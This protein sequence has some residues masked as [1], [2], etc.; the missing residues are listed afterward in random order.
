MRV[1]A[2]PEIE[3]AAAPE[4]E[5]RLDGLCVMTPAGERT[6][7]EARPL[8]L[9]LISTTHRRRIRLPASPTLSLLTPVFL[10]EPEQIRSVEC[11]QRSRHLHSAPTAAPVAA[12]HRVAAQSCATDARR[13][14]QG[15]TLR[16]KPGMAVLIT[17][18]SGCGK[19]SLLRAIAGALP[20]AASTP[21]QQCPGSN[22]RVAARRCW[23]GWRGR[24]AQ[25]ACVCEGASPA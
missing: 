13:R 22:H 18:P 19:S 7:C 12:A 21:V 17:G 24:S 3:R 6:L 16:M 25:C 11:C 23:Q 14:G 1:Q 10:L 9:T 4:G 20:P 15:L 2:G 5:L 8:A